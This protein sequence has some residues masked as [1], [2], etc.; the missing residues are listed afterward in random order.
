[1][2]N[3][4]NFIYQSTDLLKIYIKYFRSI[5]WK[6]LPSVSIWEFFFFFFILK[7]SILGNFNFKKLNKNPTTFVDDSCYSI[8]FNS[9]PNKPNI[10]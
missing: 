7:L 3:T 6:V 2:I 8:T 10:I 1:M 9:K 4:H 5:T